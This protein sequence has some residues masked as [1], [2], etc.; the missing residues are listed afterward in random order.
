M[1]FSGFPQLYGI[2]RFLQKLA[3]IHRNVCLREWLHLFVFLIFGL[4]P[5]CCWRTFHLQ[6]SSCI[7]CLAFIFSRRGIF[8]KPARQDL[9]SEVCR[10]KVRLQK[11]GLR[12]NTKIVEYMDSGLQTYNPVNADELPRKATGFRYLR[13]SKNEVIEMVNVLWNLCGTKIPGL[14]K[15]E[16]YSTIIRSTS[17]HGTECWPT[18]KKKWNACKHNGIKNAEAVI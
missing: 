5:Y 18:T 11:Y 7:P 2:C 6:N 1:P 13:S 17:M 10:W 4:K 8:G 15:L 9:Q 3:S 12:S 16:M 14:L